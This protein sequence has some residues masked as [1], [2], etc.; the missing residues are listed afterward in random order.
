MNWKTHIPG[1][2]VADLTI[3]AREANFEPFTAAES[4]ALREALKVVRP[5]AGIVA[6]NGWDEIR[7]QRDAKRA[8][9]IAPDAETAT[10]IRAT[11]YDHRSIEASALERRK[12]AKRAL[13]HAMSQRVAPVCAAALR[14]FVTWL[15]GLVAA[16]TEVSLARSR[17]YGLACT[18][19]DLLTELKGRVVSARLQLESAAAVAD[20]SSSIVGVGMPWLAAFGGLCPEEFRA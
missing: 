2:T 6:E 16:E 5:L 3:A 13:K 12:S 18:D 9:L 15:E 8:E 1:S 17:R 10:A 4:E 11:D 7:K 20:G 14:R 19:S